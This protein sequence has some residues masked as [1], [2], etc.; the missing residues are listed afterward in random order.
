VHHR[1]YDPRYDRLEHAGQP[2][3]NVR[4][5]A[6]VIKSLMG[7]RGAL[8]VGGTDP[9]YVQGVKM[10]IRPLEGE[11]RPHP[12]N[13]AKKMRNFRGLRVMCECPMCG[14]VLAAGRLNQHKCKD[15]NHA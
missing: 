8:P 12:W 2:F 7:I 13:P 10:W 9:V 1:L 15:H 14:E 11:G 3:H 4:A 6:G 5:F